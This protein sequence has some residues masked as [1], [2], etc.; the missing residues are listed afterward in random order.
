MIMTNR[1]TGNSEIEG[2]AGSMVTT[3]WTGGGAIASG[4]VMLQG[5]SVTAIATWDIHT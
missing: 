3:G 4:L 2:G 1:I 5:G